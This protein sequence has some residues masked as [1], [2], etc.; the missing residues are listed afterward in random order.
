MKITLTSRRMEITQPLREY[1]DAKIKKLSRFKQN[2]K[3]AHV[4]LSVEKYRQ[5]AE[6][7]LSGNDFSI[8]S[9]EETADMY[10]SIDRTIE[11]LERQVKKINKRKISNKRG[12]KTRSFDNASWPVEEDDEISDK[13]IKIEAFIPKPMS[14]E[15]AV[16]QIDYFDDK[17]LMFR[18]SSDDE[19][20]VIFRRD[21]NSI[22]L[23]QPE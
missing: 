21:D 10:N 22:G 1:I 11:K 5:I 3:E 2:I 13:I 16:M 8:S 23:L 19:I 6:I 17:I 9:N 15:E 14:I 4:I 12:N 18:N 7:Y 20:N